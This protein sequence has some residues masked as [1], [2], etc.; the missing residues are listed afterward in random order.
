[1]FL[2]A[3]CSLLRADGFFCSLNVF[4]GSLGISKLQFFIKKISNFFFSAVNFLSNFGHKN[5]GSGSGSVFSLKCWIRIRT[6]LETLDGADN[7]N[8]FCDRTSVSVNPLDTV[9][10]QEK[11]L[12]QKGR[13]NQIRYQEQI[14]YIV[15]LGRVGFFINRLLD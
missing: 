11:V 3:G 12:F 4:Y 14:I 5:P 2:S 10:D 1:M 6:L 15:Y 9:T 13:E 8:L 7:M